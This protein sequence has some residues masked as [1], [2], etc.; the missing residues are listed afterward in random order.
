M[1]WKLSVVMI[2]CLVLFSLSARQQISGVDAAWRQNNLVMN[3]I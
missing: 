2:C 1:P 3:S